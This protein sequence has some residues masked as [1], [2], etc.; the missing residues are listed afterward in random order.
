LPLPPEND[1]VF[2][3]IAAYRDLQLVPTVEDC[4]S[5]AEHP[6]QLRFGICWQHGA[7]Q[8]SL[9]WQHDERFRILDIPWRESQGACWARAEVMK[10]WQG[11]QWFL[12]VDSHC[13]FAPG[14]DT[15]LKQMMQQTGSPQPI[16]STYA[17]A[18]TPEN[19]V[20]AGVPLQMA[21]Q[22]FTPEGIPH[23][24]PLG[25]RNWQTLHRPLRAR[26]VSAGFLFAPGMFVQQVPYDPELYFLGEEAAMTLRA[27]T[28]GYDFFHPTEILV[29]HDYVR[30][31][32]V[33]HWDDHTEA[34]QAPIEWGQRDLL[35]RSKVKKLLAG[36]AVDPFGLGAVRTIADYEQYAGLSFRLRRAQDYT[37]RSEEPPNP[38]LEANWPDHIYSWLVRIHLKQ[39]D[40]PGSDY[41]F[42]YI[43]VH[44]EQGNEIYRRDLSQAEVEALPLHEPRLVLVC[45]LQSGS[46]PASWTVGPV[47]RAHGWLKKLQGPFAEG[48]YAIL[49]EEDD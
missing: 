38:P 10:L 14:W 44:D 2:V 48:D 45:E 12:Q 3:S 43:G 7:E 1:L 26:F 6:G 28:H 13:R 49:Q 20:L 34:N 27:F 35:S 36:E 47:S 23:M 19:E 11:E 22:G 41:A 18:F 8:S 30:K 17:T 42:W 33:K 32:A 15:K 40:L 21:L 46:I 29:W 9:P 37:T 39:E 4:I 5:K 24:R 31:D 25:I 16:L